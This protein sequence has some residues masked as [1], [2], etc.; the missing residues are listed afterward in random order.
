[1]LLEEYSINEKS[2][3][4]TI[5]VEK[6]VA[7]ISF[8]L[9]NEFHVFLGRIKSQNVYYTILKCKKISNT[10]PVESFKILD[11]KNHVFQSK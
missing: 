2:K 11:N 10:L 4:N 8:L 6:R 9:Q 7:L 1:M 3:W 5:N